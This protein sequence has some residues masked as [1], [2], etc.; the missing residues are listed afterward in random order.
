MAAL[1]CDLCGG[2]LIMGAGGI[3]TCESCGMEHS[4]DRMKEKVQEIKGT[5]RVDNSHMIE[6]YLEMANRAYGSSNNAE[7]E[8]YCNKIIEIDP[9]NYQALML[10]GKAA[11]WQSSLQNSRFEEAI[12]CFATAITNAPDEV[13][14]NCISDAKEQISSLSNALMSLQA[15][16]FVKWP[17]EEEAAGLLHVIVVTMQ[18]LLQFIQTI[19]AGI[20]DKDELMS[21]L[22]TQINNS[23]MN[24]W[25]NKIVPEYRNDSDGHPDD[26]AFKQLIERAGFCTD[27][28]EKAI[29]LSDADDEA[30]ITRY[31]NLIAIHQYLISSCS[32]EY[33]TVNAGNSIWDGSTIWENRYVKNLELNDNAKRTRNNL[34]ST[35]RTKISNIKTAIK[36]KQDAEKAEAERKAREE[37]QKR[38]DAYWAEHAEEKASLEAEKKDLSSQIAALRASSN[39]QVAALNKE[40]AAIPGKAE[41]DNIEERIKKLTEEKSALGI[42]KGKEK[43]ALQEQIDQANAE[44]KSVQDRM[45]AA[46]KEIE[47]KIASVKAEIQKKVT[48]LQNRV[49]TISNEL[50][51]ERSKLGITAQTLKA[52]VE[53]K[54]PGKFLASKGNSANAGFVQEKDNARQWEARIYEKTAEKTSNNIWIRCETNSINSEVQLIELECDEKNIMPVK[55]LVKT[56]WM[57]P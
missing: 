14:D 23:V 54:M 5:V 2:K 42:F 27:L 33:K 21:P 24:A 36:R 43:K 46:K 41:I 47:A 39:D 38:F 37:A 51:K 32:Y 1:V 55:E 19:G 53:Q 18:S 3:A 6:N 56:Q 13:K 57:W 22:A 26:Y 15:D 29:G 17:D 45:D 4:A 35:Y 16:R 48:P 10:K 8:N 52:I 20:I 44:K 7:A 25:N 30:D 40:I 31:E 34:I 49:N 50:T 9:N 28:L 11:G 12:N